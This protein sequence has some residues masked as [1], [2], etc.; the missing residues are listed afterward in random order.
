MISRKENAQGR[1]GLDVGSLGVVRMDIG[2]VFL[3]APGREIQG[4]HHGGYHFST[5]DGGG[6]GGKDEQEQQHAS[7]EK[8]RTLGVHGS[9][10]FVGRICPRQG[11]GGKCYTPLKRKM[12]S[13]EKLTASCKGIKRVLFWGVEGF[14]RTLF[15]PERAMVICL[16]RAIMG[17]F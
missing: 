14:S 2:E 8:T 5:R 4:L 17:P 16:R 10:S 6:G 9:N 13:A 3:A 11:G 1:G 12:V 15:S 7:E